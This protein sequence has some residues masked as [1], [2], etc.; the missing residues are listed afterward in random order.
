MGSLRPGLR[1]TQTWGGRRRRTRPRRGRRSSSAR[2][3][4]TAHP[5]TAGSPSPLRAGGTLSQSMLPAACLIGLGPLQTGV[6][7]ACLRRPLPPLSTCLGVGCRWAARGT[8]SGEAH[9]LG[10]KLA[11]A[12]FAGREI[13]AAEGTAGG[14]AGAGPH[15]AAP[16]QAA[17]P[18]AAGGGPCRRAAAH[19]EGEAF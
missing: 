8:L 12:P 5:A 1:P 2:Y 14:G 18:A 9:H 17:A 3:V 19:K 10:L 7:S 15:P 13:A 11:S 4:P 6:A 16:S